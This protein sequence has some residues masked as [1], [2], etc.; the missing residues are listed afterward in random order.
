MDRTLH[1]ALDVY[2]FIAVTASDET[3]DALI[4]LVQ[5]GKEKQ[6]WATIPRDGDPG[7]S[8]LF[9]E[10]VGI[11]TLHDLYIRCLFMVELRENSHQI[12]TYCVAP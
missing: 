4:N 8:D 2:A 6:Y 10:A 1:K 9:S 11:V 12:S 7:F 3:L 5:K